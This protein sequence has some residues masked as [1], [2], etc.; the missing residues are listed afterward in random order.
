MGVIGWVILALVIHFLV[1]GVSLARA[2]EGPGAD[3][4]SAAGTGGDGPASGHEAPG[5]KLHC[6]SWH[7]T[8]DLFLVGSSPLSLA[9]LD[10]VCSLGATWQGITPQQVSFFPARAPPLGT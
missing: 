2:T 5:C 7:G 3:I 8:G 9:T 4:C 10:H 1:P 6:L